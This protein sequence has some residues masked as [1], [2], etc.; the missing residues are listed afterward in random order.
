V[1]PANQQSDPPPTRADMALVDRGLAPSRSAAQRLIS[2]GAVTVRS[3]GHPGSS[4]AV[5][6]SAEIIEPCDE[7]GVIISDE[8][9]F[10]SRGGLKLAKALKQT[11]VDAEGTR[12]L[13]IG[14]STG[15]FT[16]CLLQAGARS[17]IGVDVGHDQLHAQLRQ[18]NRVICFEGVNARHLSGEAL[19]TALA[20]I[21]RPEAMPEAGFDIAVV[22]TSFISLTLIFAPIRPLLSRLGHLLAL[23]KPQFEVGPG[24]LN[25]RGIVRDQRLYASVEAAVRQ[26]AA[27]NVLRVLDWF[28]SPVLGGDGNREFIMHARPDLA[29][30]NGTALLRAT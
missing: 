21:G 27:G 13:D 30:E 5:N 1:S 11:G 19:R 18:D 9:R 4:R 28:D 10:V 25:G 16:D 2:A 3:G 20:R 26:A 24:N 15:G 17:V 22:D 8:I 23:V 29:R 6:K 12:C 14:Q 7:L